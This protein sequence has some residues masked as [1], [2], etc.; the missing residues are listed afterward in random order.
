M[1]DCV[2][3]KIVKGEIPC[4]QI[5]EDRDFLAFLDI[6]PFVE[7]HTLVIPKKHYRWVWDMPEVGEYFSVVQKIAVRFQKVLNDKYVRSFIAGDL[8]SHA[9]IHL[10][11]KPYGLP[12]DWPRG[13]LTEE[14]GKQLVQKLAFI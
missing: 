2:F 11:P 14:K 8:V 10:L 9:H 1:A 4:Y 3:C 5:Y 13:K 7:G 12:G 6:A